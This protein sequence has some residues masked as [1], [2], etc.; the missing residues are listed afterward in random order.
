MG[1]HPFRDD[2]GSKDICEGASISK[3][4][5]APLRTLSNFSLILEHYQG[6]ESAEVRVPDGV[7]QILEGAFKDHGELVS[8]ELP[9]TLQSIGA[10][11]FSGCT[12][13]REIRVPESVFEVGRAAFSGCRCLE[14]VVLPDGLLKVEQATFRGCSSLVCVEGG[15]EVDE[16]ASGAFSGC[17]ALEGLSLLSHVRVIGSDAL[18][19]CA[20]REVELPQAMESIA[21][22]AFKSCRF[23]TRVVLP[24]EIDAMGSGVFLNCG[25][26]AAM[27]GADN[28]AFRFP[29]AF[30]RN[31]A[32]ELGILRPQDVRRETGK[33]VRCH[34]EEAQAARALLAECRSDIRLLK[35]QRDELGVFDRS[36]RREIEGALDAVRERR[37]SLKAQLEAL[38]HPTAD[39][40][41]EWKHAQKIS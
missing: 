10:K 41:A 17:E 32:D 27:E 4:A 30:P 25:S 19:D 37:E 26:L 33:Y 15:A 20:L 39:L 23:L 5:E 1:S 38:E 31:F 9:D 28:L 24:E 21:D 35:E 7:T 22:G 2:V 11:A 13:L 16:L 40:V 3:D 29:D 36:Q 34:R 18:S 12:A 14:R 6:S 8:V